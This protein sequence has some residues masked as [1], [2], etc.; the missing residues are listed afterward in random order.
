MIFCCCINRS[1]RK[2]NREFSA[3]VHVVCA[4]ADL[5]GAVFSCIYLAHMKMGLRDRLA[6]LHQTDNNVADVFSHLI[7]L[8]YFKTAVEQ[9]FLQFFRGNIDIYIFFQPT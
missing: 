8:F 5:H 1:A 3:G 4:A 2:G 9:F 6:A 7:T